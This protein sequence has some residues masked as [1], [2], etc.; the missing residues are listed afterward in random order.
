[1][2]KMI[3]N[4]MRL[5]EIDNLQQEDKR[6]FHPIELLSLSKDVYTRVLPIADSKN[7]RLTISGAKATVMGDSSML[8]NLIYNITEN[9]IKYTNSGGE[10]NILVGIKD[11]KSFIE[12]R[13][14]GV[15]ID[16]KDI[17]HI[18]ERFY[19]VDKN[20]S[21]KTGGNGIGLALVKHIAEYHSGDISVESNLGEGT[22]FTVVF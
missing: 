3:E 7:I 16:S 15:G 14:N 22:V 1:M 20:R 13:D 6:D 4:I 11:S 19:R 17:P 5:S 2:V 21:S 12:I 8:E 18:F 10:I 9:A